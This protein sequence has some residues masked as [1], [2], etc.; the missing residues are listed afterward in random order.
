M[1]AP[2]STSYA[3]SDRY[4]AAGNRE[5][6]NKWPGDADARSLE[7]Q[8]WAKGERGGEV[9]EGV[10][11]WGWRGEVADEVAWVSVCRYKTPCRSEP[12]RKKVKDG[13]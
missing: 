5:A 6:N 10:W 9:E 1:L 13:G 7:E 2:T 12:C 11:L 8:G 4:L 3:P